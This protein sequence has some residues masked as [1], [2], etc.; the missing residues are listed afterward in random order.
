MPIANLPKLGCCGA[1]GD[2]C[3]AEVTMDIDD[4][5][6]VQDYGTDP[7]NL[8]SATFNGFHGYPV[9]YLD[10]G[11]IA[12]LLGRCVSEAEALVTV[13]ASTA[14]GTK[15]WFRQYDVTATGIIYEVTAANIYHH[16][17][18]PFPTPITGINEIVWE[19][20]TVPVVDE[21]IANACSSD[22]WGSYAWWSSTGIMRGGGLHGDEIFSNSIR[23]KAYCQAVQLNG[24]LVCK[25]TRMFGWLENGFYTCEDGSME[26]VDFK[27]IRIPSINVDQ[28]RT[29][30]QVASDPING[31]WT[32]D[33]QF[34]EFQRY[35]ASESSGAI[36]PTVGWSTSSEGYPLEEAP[37]CC[38][39]DP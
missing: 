23:L 13:N 24:L 8:V 11:V 19:G 31:D 38:D 3:I 6:G 28:F 15:K 2:V 33:G 21:G 37:D 22:P 35:L 14:P 32:L 10:G 4:S 1:A 17:T 29:P 5:R 34:Q 25:F 36:F 7:S 26:T 30:A 9:T 20:L 16:D 39:F 12:S 18:N 27:K